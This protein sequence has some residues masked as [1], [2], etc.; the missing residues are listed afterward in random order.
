[1]QHQSIISLQSLSR[2]GCR[3]WP[4]VYTNK[5]ANMHTANIIYD[6]WYLPLGSV[7]ISLLSE[8]LFR[9]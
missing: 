6:I 7:S 5:V 2:K 4:K 1:M 8:K 3:N 9:R